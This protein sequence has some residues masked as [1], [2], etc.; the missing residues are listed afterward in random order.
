MDETEKA[1]QRSELSM[2]QDR[3]RKDFPCVLSGTEQRLLARIEIL[4]KANL[5]LQ[6]KQ[7]ELEGRDWT[8]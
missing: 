4:E 8:E 1:L 5:E 3:D 7:F 6:F 2:R